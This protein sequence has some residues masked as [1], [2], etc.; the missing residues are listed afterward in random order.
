M[1]TPTHRP[2]PTPKPSEGSVTSEW[3]ETSVSSDGSWTKNFCEME[4]WFALQTEDETM[5][6][7]VDVPVPRLRRWDV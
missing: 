6:H 3:S 4:R 1:R 7:N 5:E 2:S